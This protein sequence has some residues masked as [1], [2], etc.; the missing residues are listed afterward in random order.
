MAATKAPPVTPEW[1]EAT[2]WLAYTGDAAREAV[3][4]HVGGDAREA[5]DRL[6]IAAWRSARTAEAL[7]EAA[8]SLGIPDDKAE[9][10]ATPGAR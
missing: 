10:G 3:L 5:R 2:N 9:E 4:L 8:R 7:R 6:L 1:R